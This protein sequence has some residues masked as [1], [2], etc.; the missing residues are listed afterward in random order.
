M[1]QNCRVWGGGGAKLNFSEAVVSIALH[2]YTYCDTVSVRSFS[3]ELG[4]MEKSFGFV[5]H[6]I[7]NAPAKTTDT[8]D[9][10]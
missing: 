6:F 7:T 1:M 10:H 3:R 9:I 5:M 8:S 4:T 2:Y